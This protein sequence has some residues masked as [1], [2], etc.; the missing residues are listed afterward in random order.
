[1]MINSAHEPQA[2]SR[3]DQRSELGGAP[4][5]ITHAVAM[6]AKY[7]DPRKVMGQ[8]PRT[9]SGVVADETQDPKI[10]QPGKS[11]SKMSLVD[12]AT[13]MAKSRKSKPAPRP[14]VRADLG[15]GA[16]GSCR[17]EVLRTKRRRFGR[18]VGPIRF[19]IGAA[20]YQ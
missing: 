11:T 5:D 3:T 9:R 12:M 15:D 16:S 19:M 13:E 6:A 7:A 17:T 18:L 14:I 1:M 10:E 20:P 4:R 8:T 2:A